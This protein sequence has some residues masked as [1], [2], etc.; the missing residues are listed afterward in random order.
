[1]AGMAGTPSPTVSVIVL[2]WNGGGDLLDCLESVFCQRGIDFDLTLVDNASRDDSVNAALAAYPGLRVLRNDHNVGF[3]GGINVGIAATSGRFLALINPD[4][5]AHAEWLV[6][7]V[8]VVEGGGHRVGCVAPK[9]LLRG[10]AG[11]PPSAILDSCGHVLGRDGQNFCRGRSERDVGQYDAVCEVVA[12][13]GAACLLRREMLEEIGGFDEG[14]FLYG[15]D[16]ELGL[17]ARLRGW[18]TL[19]APRAIVRHRLSASLGRY[20]LR[21]A[22]Y[23][24]RNRLRLLWLHFPWHLVTAAPL[25]R[26]ASIGRY[27]AFARRRRGEYPRWAAAALPPT[28]LAAK[29]SALFR[30]PSILLRRRREGRLLVSGRALIFRGIFP[31][32]EITPGQV[33]ERY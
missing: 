29:I 33:A 10:E 8:R 19:T 4:A 9:V 27:F 13:S 12:F 20:S 5:V 14:F 16:A 7:M 2:N 17:R 28:L 18:R 26:L 3:G 24:E 1:M 32:F 11:A 6:E 15:E 25:L 23:I 30:L 31:A 22:Y 21:K